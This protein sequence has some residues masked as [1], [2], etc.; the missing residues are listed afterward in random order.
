MF[1]RDIKTARSGISER[2]CKIRSTIYF[3]EVFLLRLI[4]T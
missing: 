4:E 3:S 2:A 1:S